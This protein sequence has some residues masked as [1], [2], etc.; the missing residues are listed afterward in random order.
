MDHF[1]GTKNRAHGGQR[2]IT[3]RVVQTKGKKAIEGRINKQGWREGPTDVVYRCEDGRKYGHW[4]FI[5][6]STDR[7]R[8]FCTTLNFAFLI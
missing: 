6:M 1:P 4:V 5:D 2:E 8:F 3:L 7:G